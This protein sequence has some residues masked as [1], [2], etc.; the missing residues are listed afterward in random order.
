[1]VDKRKTIFL[2][3]AIISVTF[4]VLFSI[5]IAEESVWLSLFS[6]FASTMTVG[7]GFMLKKRL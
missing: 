6:L 5:G 4:L 3:L 7:L 1:M 2:A